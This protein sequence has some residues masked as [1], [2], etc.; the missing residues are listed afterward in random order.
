[1]TV[2]SDDD[3][4]SD[5]NPLKTWNTDVLKGAR[6]IGREPNPGP[7]LKGLLQ[8]AGFEDVVQGVW[9]LPI[10]TW[11]KNKKLVCDIFQLL[12]VVGF[13]M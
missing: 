6:M 11:P 9:K 12:L 7:L 10:G 1:M 3:S 8:D 2:Y 4:L 5:T 13:K